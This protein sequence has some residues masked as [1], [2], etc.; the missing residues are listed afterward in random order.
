MILFFLYQLVEIKII[1]WIIELGDGDKVKQIIPNT[2]PTFIK[3]NAQIRYSS[4]YMQ[5]L[6]S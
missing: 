2:Q 5:A 1:L 4:C 6:L 3:H